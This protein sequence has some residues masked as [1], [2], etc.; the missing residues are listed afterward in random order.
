MPFEVIP[1]IDVA[2]GSL[3]RL[4]AGG[5]VP[6]EAFDG[7]PL[8]AAGAF[9]DAGARWIHFVDVEQAI[10]GEPANLEVLRRVAGLGVPVQASGGF[11]SGTQVSGAMSAG[12]TRVVLGSAALTFRDATEKL[13]TMMGDALAI[14][15]EA[16]GPMIRPRGR[17]RELPLWETLTW[18]ADVDV[19]RFVFTEVDKVGDLSGPDL[20]GIWALAT[21]TEKPVIA[22]GGIRSA[23]DVRAVAGLGGTVEGVIVG[24]A[25]QEGMDL[26]E[27]LAAA[28]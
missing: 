25:L 4:T 27:A 11:T 9:V 2:G 19:R 20:D 17:G 21:H 24:R 26:R 23:D 5:P 6:V 1:A 14:G 28:G 3:A 7:D 12:A 13:V 8:A 15:I 18:L 22:S 10:S 16:E